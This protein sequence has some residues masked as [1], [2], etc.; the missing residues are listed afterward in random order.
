MPYDAAS[1][2]ERQREKVARAKA[3]GLCRKGM[4]HGPVVRGLTVCEACRAAI[5]ESNRQARK[6]RALGGLCRTTGCSNHPEPGAQQCGE[7][8]A[9]VRALAKALRA[10][11][12]SKGLC[13]LC[14]F[15][16][17]RPGR[18]TCADCE[19]RRRAREASREVGG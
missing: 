6:K 15:M 4:S 17:V 1:E 9:V 11:A 8:L 16:P 7:C 2:R 10:E 3:L 5:E 13:M 19:E 18:S 14:M 12:R